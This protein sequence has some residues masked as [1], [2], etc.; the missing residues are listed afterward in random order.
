MS[1]N[2]DQ[3][4]RYGYQYNIKILGFSEHTSESAS[5]TTALCLKLSKLREWEFHAKTLA[6]PIK[7]P[8]EMQLFVQDQ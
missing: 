7:F 3:F 8:K 6:L 1:R 2:L 4:L 5:T